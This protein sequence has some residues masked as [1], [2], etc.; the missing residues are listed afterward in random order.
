MEPDDT[1]VRTQKYRNRTVKITLIK[2]AGPLDTGQKKPD[3][4]TNRNQ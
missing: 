3:T 2:R 1:E 4:T